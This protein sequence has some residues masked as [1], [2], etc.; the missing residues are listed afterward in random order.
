MEDDNSFSAG[1]RFHDIAHTTEYI[2][3]LLDDRCIEV[4]VLHKL[5]MP[6]PT[7]GNKS[8]LYFPAIYSRVYC[9]LR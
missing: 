6:Y 9:I 4:G 8:I 3:F 2:R 1:L 5:I 7:G